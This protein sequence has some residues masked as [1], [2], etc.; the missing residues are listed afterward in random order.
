MAKRVPSRPKH[1]AMPARTAPR[2]KEHPVAGPGESPQQSVAGKQPL[3][4]IVGVGASAGGLEAFTAFLKH[5]PDDSGMAFVLIQHLDPK[6][7]SRLTDLLSKVTKMPV[8]VA[9]A[10]TPV[11]PNQR[12]RHGAGRMPEHVGWAQLPGPALPGAG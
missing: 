10:D 2:A 12:L 6:Q 5:L 8:L 3:F 7:H 9:D 11:E 1:R 4:P